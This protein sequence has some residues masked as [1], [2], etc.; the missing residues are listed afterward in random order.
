MN[1][2]ALETWHAA[3]LPGALGNMAI[4]AIAA[5]V[6]LFICVKVFDKAIT[7]VDLEAEIAKGNIAAGI[8]VGAIVLGVSIILAVAMM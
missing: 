8:V 2:N 3:S 6:L 1:T 5:I 7:K 4:F